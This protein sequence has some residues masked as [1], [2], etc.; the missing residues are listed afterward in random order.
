MS[1]LSGLMMN[2]A[3][4]V[5]DST[6]SKAVEVER[7]ASPI[8]GNLTRSCYRGGLHQASPADIKNKERGLEW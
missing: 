5:I 3:R 8:M 2:T 4:M 7:L 1:L 6:L